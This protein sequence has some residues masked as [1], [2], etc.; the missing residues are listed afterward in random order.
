ML[1]MSEH[2][3]AMLIFSSRKLVTLLDSSVGR[4]DHPQKHIAIYNVFSLFTVFPFLEAHQNDRQYLLKLR[5]P[6][7]VEKSR[8]HH[9]ILVSV[10]QFW[11]RCETVCW[12]LPQ[13]KLI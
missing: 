1:Q 3:G 13:L 2:A 7:I 11:S 12:P 6:K 8:K 5:H 10:R 4:L 9:L